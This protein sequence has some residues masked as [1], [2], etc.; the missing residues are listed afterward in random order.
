M[1]ETT[2]MSYGL[3][4]RISDYR[5][6]TLWDHGGATDGFRARIMLAPRD[7]V[8]VVV[9]V[10]L[11]DTE[12]AYAVGYALLDAALG[13]PKK[14]WNT[15]YT[16]QLKEFEARRKARIETRAATRKPHTKPSHDLEAYVGVYEDPAYG[17]LRI[18]LDGGALSLHW[19]S[20]DKLLRHFHYD[21][22]QI[23]ELEV[24]GASPLAGELAVFSLDAQ[25][26]PDGV[27]LL[28]RKFKRR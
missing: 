2:Q 6:K 23:D 5:G 3:G 13:L 14:D 16:G 19:S 4:W 27:R 15:F 24:A 20:Y 25:G 10:N 9:L 26:Q 18:A 8:G 21:T 17:T 11:E 12:I 28:G 7:K 1:A 22:F